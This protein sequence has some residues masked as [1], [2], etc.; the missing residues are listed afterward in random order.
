MTWARLDDG[1]PLHRK[2]RKA[3]PVGV[4]LAVAG[5]CYCSRQLTDG[6]IP[7]V[8]L[9]GVWPWS[10][11]P[12]QETAALLVDVGVWHDR[13]D[14]Y[15]V[16]DY[17]EYNPSREY[18]LAERDRKA[19]AGRAGGMAAARAR[20][21]AP[22]IAPAKQAATPVP[23]APATGGRVPHPGPLHPDPSTTK[24]P[25][26][27]VVEPEPDD[28]DDARAALI[29]GY[30]ARYERAAN[31]LWQSSGK[32]RAD[33]TTVAAYVVASARASNRAWQAIC[34]EVLDGVFADAWMAEKRWPWAQ[35]AKDPAKYR[36]HVT[37]AAG[38]VQTRVEQ[39]R[40]QLRDLGTMDMA[41][42]AK[43]RA[44]L[45]ALRGTG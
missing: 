9:E 25:S 12:L 45:A 1:F 39:L 10:S 28:S 4:A 42:S 35:I 3:G 24:P 16:H 23:V 11:L 43:I 26:V 38:P 34:D 6:R 44:E 19:A 27:H 5:I 32:S 29:R 20:A 7:K 14:H 37:G 15:E 30:A 40:A 13:G 41:R 17:L 22:A 36:V 31:D 8:D 21:V 18:V 2:A 33:I